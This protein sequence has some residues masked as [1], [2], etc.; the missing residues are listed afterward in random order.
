MAVNGELHS[1][2][3]VTKTDCSNVHTF[4]S[5]RGPVGRVAFDGVRFRAETEEGRR[6]KLEF[7][8]IDLR[9]ALVKTFT[10]MDERIVRAALEGAQGLV[11]E[12]TGAG[13]VPDSIVPAIVEARDRGLPVVVVS[14]CWRGLLSPTYGTAGGG[15]SLRALGC[16]LGM[17]LN[18]QKARILLMAA[19]GSQLQGE[20]LRLLFEQQ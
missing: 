12:G 2:W 11:L 10:G 9:V 19:L 17:E 14:R 8:D 18:A 16:L 13:N 20:A 5:S 15:R 3:D 4:E 7:G 6:T 1:A